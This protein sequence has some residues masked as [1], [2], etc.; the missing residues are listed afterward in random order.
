MIAH[1]AIHTPKPESV[2]PLIAS[3]QLFAAVG[4]KQAGLRD[5]RTMRD[6]ESGKVLGLAIWDSMEAFQG[7]VVAMR[8]AVEDDPFSDWEER[9]PEVYLF[10]D[11]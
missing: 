1:L 10:E 8:A 6:A 9:P 3:M 5:V 11:V 7:G 2:E 4:R